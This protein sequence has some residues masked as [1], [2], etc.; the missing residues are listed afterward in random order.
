MPATATDVSTAQTFD[1]G[2]FLQNLA[3]TGLQ[4]AAQKVAPTQST[5]APSAAVNPP[6]IAAPGGTQRPATA[7]PGLAFLSTPAGMAV[8][9]GGGL[10][11]VYLLVRKS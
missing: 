1:V 8:L 3:N 6:A 7:T 11:A 4:I 5:G 2:S 10:L 9:I